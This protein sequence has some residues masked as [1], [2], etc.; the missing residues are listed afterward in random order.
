MRVQVAYD[1]HGRIIALADVDSS[2]G[3]SVR[4]LPMDGREVTEIEVPDEYTDLPLSGLYAR[5]RLE[6]GPEGPQAHWQA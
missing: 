6:V 3:V 2:G 5:L 1:Q 4:P